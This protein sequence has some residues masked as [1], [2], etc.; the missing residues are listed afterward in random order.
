MK[1]SLE[2][3]IGNTPLLRLKLSDSLPATV[4]LK[5]ENRNPGGSIKDRIALYCINGALQ[6]GELG[7]GGTMVEA[8]SG[9]TGIGM[10]ML[11]AARGLKCILVM[12]E[13]MSQERRSLLRGYGAKLIL[14]PA[15]KGMSGAVEEAQRI[16]REDG[17]WLLNQFGNPDAVTAHYETTAPEIYRDSHGRMDFLVAGVGSGSSIT[18]TGCR[19]K[20]LIP[21]FRVL[22]VE[23]KES[24]VLS[25]GKSGPHP[26]QG[27]GAGFV[28]EVL[29]RN[30]LD[31]IILVDGDS[32]LKMARR[33]M[34]EAGICGGISSGANVHA[35]LSLASRPE[36][37]GKNIVTFIC[38]T[39]ERY[40]STAL[41][42]GNQ[43]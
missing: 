24:P 38:D 20:E 4:W 7:Q 12:P 33:L 32:A 6:R 39:G 43:I 19:L 23:P 1:E 5:L 18:G 17:A 2:Q 11:C 40:L 29:E 37:A 25:G 27:I 10:A 15:A 35:A 26:I 42:Q 14:T 30:L 16:A 31:E 8:T 21:G 13:S 36:L 28:P 3:C 9:N 22:A 41:F 34:R